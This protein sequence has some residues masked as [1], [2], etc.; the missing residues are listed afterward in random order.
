M[1][2]QAASTSRDVKA[3]KT[4]KAGTHYDTAAYLAFLRRVNRATA[5]RADDFN[6]EDLAELH[7]LI[8]E[9]RET[10]TAIAQSLN[11][12]GISWKAIGAPQGL[13]ASNAFR[14]YRTSSGRA[15]RRATATTPTA[16]DDEGG[17]ECAA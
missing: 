3:R 14:N 12:A 4:N 2:R 16:D 13:A 8:G 11:D 10:E 5:A 15:D 1:A 17:A 7:T 6:P 9:L